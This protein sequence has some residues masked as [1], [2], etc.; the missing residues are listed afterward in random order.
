MKKLLPMLLIVL[1]VGTVA[2]CQNS[3]KDHHMT[4]EQHANM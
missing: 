4:A 1:V 3:A 2:G